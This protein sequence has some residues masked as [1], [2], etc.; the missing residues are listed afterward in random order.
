MGYP[1]TPERPRSIIYTKQA[2]EQQKV[3]AIKMQKIKLCPEYAQVHSA[4]KK[5]QAVTTKHVH[6]R[7]AAG[8]NNRL[9]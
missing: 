5:V 1:Y 8:R 6:R 4:L 2:I 7:I 3:T 9:N